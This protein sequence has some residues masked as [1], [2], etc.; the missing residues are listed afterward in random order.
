MSEFKKTIFRLASRLSLVR[1]RFWTMVYRPFLGSCGNRARLAKVQ[2]MTNPHRIHLADRVVIYP[3]ARLDVI[4]PPIQQQY[5]MITIGSGTSIEP[6]AHIAAAAEMKVGRNVVIASHVYITDHDHGFSNIESSALDQPLTVKNV[7]IEDG[8][9]LGEHS[10]VLKGV[11]IGHHSIIGANSV[12]T[13]NLPPFSIAA[14]SP[15]RVIRSWN[16]E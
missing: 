3:G 15:A 4:G 14:G 10:I 13:H 16:P 6:Q 8:V 5:G 7:T 2:Q 11:T 9:W 12:V 1:M